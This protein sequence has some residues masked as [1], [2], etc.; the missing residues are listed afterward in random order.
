MKR[1]RKPKPMSTTASVMVENPD[2]RRHRDGDKAFPRYMQATVRILPGTFAWRFG[3]DKASLEYRAGNRFAMLWERAGI[4]VASSADFLRGIGGGYRMGISDGRVNAIDKL[5]GVR[6]L[7]GSAGIERLLDY[8]VHGMTTA[9]I[10]A[11]HKTEERAMA[12]I[13]Q[14][15]L[16]V[17]AG[18][19]GMGVKRPRRVA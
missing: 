17:V 19:W 18:H 16:M 15:D 4:A 13:L 7:L 10:A 9:D 3:R 2:W 1:K 6:D 11:K 8:C 12:N 5:A 14:M